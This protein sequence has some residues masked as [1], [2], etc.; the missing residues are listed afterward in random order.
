MPRVALA[1]GEI[2]YARQVEPAAERLPLLLLHGAGGSHLDW[3]VA[4]RRLPGMTRLAPD[5]AGHGVDG[6]F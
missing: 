6:R 2:W 5:L 1:D 3:P 4:L